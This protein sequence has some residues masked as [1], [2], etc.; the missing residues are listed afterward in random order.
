MKGRPRLRR[1]AWIAVVVIAIAGV[2]FFARQ[3]LR[4]PSENELPRLADGRVEGCLSCHG[5]FVGLAGPHEVAKIGCSACHMG[6]A[7][8]LDANGAHE[9]MELLSGDLSTVFGT[10][11]RSEC[12]VTQA[13]RVTRSVMARAPGILSVDRFAFEE[14]DTPD[15][16]PAGLLDLD[17][18][19]PPR[20]PAE[21]H[22]RKL[23][24]SCHLASRKERPGDEGFFARG[25]GC[26]ACHLAPPDSLGSQANGPRH[27]DVSAK[28]AEERCVG[29]HSRSGRIALSYRGI[30]ELEASD[31][32]VTG[33]LPD[34]RPSGAAPA[35]VH[36]KAGMTCID[37]HVERE[38]MG[39]GEDHRHA[40]EA[41]E[42]RCA[43]CHASGGCRPGEDCARPAFRDVSRPLP[44]EDAARAA[45]V[46]RA[47]WRRRGMPALPEG[48]PLR[49]SRGTE[50]WRTSAKERSLALATSG[51]RRAIPA[52]S[53]RAHHTLPGHA[54]LSCQACHSRWAPRC[55]E[56]HTRFDPQGEDVDHLL[57]VATK[58]RWIERAGGNGF[59]APLLAVG[60]RGTIDPFVEGMKLR[61][62]GLDSPIDRTLW[63]PLEPHTTGPS[64]T[65][66]S[67][68]GEGA[69]AEVYP[70]IG[71]TTRG[72]AR[73]LDA[74]ERERIARPGLCIGCHPGYEDRIYEDFPGS[75]QR[76]RDG[77]AGGCEGDPGA[78]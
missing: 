55:T 41:L 6:N 7:E 47:G 59:G 32:R 62:E 66:A 18:T 38:L 13:A 63:A 26:A 34:G 43:D 54:R 68:H 23:C 65:C 75:M 51:E 25:G 61:I 74:D 31:P 76:L 73:L 1:S 14:R 27:P 72:A 9:G 42:I 48:P 3:R 10:C 52:A 69:I 50:L 67:C 70:A 21:S 49:T 20:S 16:R 5:D 12:H 77:A 35:D 46:L 56:C 15:G 29:C 24:G 4:G 78:L 64:R 28:V 57:G 58:G 19:K 45:D 30:V 71:E 39:N 33:R 17:G 8:A 37:C 53:E 36:A 11:G 44:D 60:P 2:I 40:H 22:V